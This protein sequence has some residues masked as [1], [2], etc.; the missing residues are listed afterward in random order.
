[1]I[2]SWE[3][4]LNI[5]GKTALVTGSSRGMGRAIAVALA[6]AGADVCV[7][8]VNNERA[9][10][11]AL[12]EIKESSG[13][14]IAVR[15]DVSN[16]DD[17]KMLVERTEELLGPIDI[18]VNH[19]HGSINRMPFLESTWDEHERQIGWVVKSAYVLSRLVAGG[20]MERGWGRIVNIGNNMVAEP[21]PGYSAYSVAMAGMLGLTRNLAAEI[22]GSNV[23]VNMVSPG[24]VMTDDMPNTTESVREA[25]RR[26]TPLGRLAVPEDIAG[27]VIFFCSELSRFMTG[28]DISVDGGKVM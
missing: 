4:C 7:N 3:S 8:Y 13:R 24:F 16:E 2:R 28:A 14:G 27:A 6:H 22:G 1:M 17:A 11:D 9:A 25:I 5:K 12:A 15:A 23:T 21:V 18:L 19:A 26:D 20:M 10:E